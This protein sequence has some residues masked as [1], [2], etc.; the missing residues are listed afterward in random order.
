MGNDKAAKEMGAGCDADAKPAHPQPL[1]ER[2]DESG[3]DKK[4]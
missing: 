1:G 4:G 3:V 2:K